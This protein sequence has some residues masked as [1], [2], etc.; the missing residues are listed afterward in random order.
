MT[1]SRRLAT[2]VTP[3]A[4]TAWRSQGARSHGRDRSRWPSTL[5]ET[6]SSR[7]PTTGALLIAV[8]SSSGVATFRRWLTVGYERVRSTASSPRTAMTDGPSSAGIRSG[9]RGAGLLDEGAEPRDDRRVVALAQAGRH[10]RDEELA[11]QS[12]GEQ[13]RAC[14]VA[15]LQHQLDILQVLG[16]LAFGLE[17]P[18]QHAL[19]L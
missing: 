16:E 3:L 2:K 13:R 11:V 10:A 14:G 5:L 9:R 18:L 6:M 7:R 19:A 12:R 4:L 1:R 8:R 17:V 15:D